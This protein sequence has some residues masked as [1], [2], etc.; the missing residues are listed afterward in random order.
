MS[1]LA[2]CL[3]Y[4]IAAKQNSDPLWKNVKIIIIYIK[5]EKQVL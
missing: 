2:T 3:R 4:H 1:H 5:K